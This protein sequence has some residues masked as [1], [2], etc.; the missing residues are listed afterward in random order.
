MCAIYGPQRDKGL[1]VEF[2][3]SGLVGNVL[4]DSG[5]MVSGGKERGGG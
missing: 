4:V 2:L 1:D 5:E 3:G